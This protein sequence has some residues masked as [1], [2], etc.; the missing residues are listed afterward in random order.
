MVGAVALFSVA[1]IIGCAHTG[2]LPTKVAHEFFRCRD[3]ALGD[4]ETSLVAAGY[5][6]QIAKESYVQTGYRQDIATGLATAMLVGAHM[7]ASVRITVLREGTDVRWSA[8]ETMSIQA[9]SGLAASN[10]MQNEQELVPTTAWIRSE[11]QRD[12]LNRLRASVCGGGD[13]F[14]GDEP[15]ANVRA[16]RKKKSRF[17]R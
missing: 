1:T 4:A 3:R 2:P 11:A 5:P 15:W 8:W 13:Y 17:R 9:V 14:T 7:V 12:R 10:A 6:I 16:K